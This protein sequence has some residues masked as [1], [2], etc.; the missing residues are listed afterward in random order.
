MTQIF[1]LESK[2][3]SVFVSHLGIK[4]EGNSVKIYN[5]NLFNYRSGKHAVNWICPHFHLIHR[6]HYPKKTI[7]NNIIFVL[8]SALI[9]I[10]TKWQQQCCLVLVPIIS[11]P[12]SR[13][14]KPEHDFIIGRFYLIK[15]IH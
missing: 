6:L 11:G 2:S 5:K 3:D 14:T 7:S 9:V 12:G 15:K 1:A 8:D 13:V 4:H 10:V